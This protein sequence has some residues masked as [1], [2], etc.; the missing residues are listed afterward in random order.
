MKTAR[1]TNDPDLDKNFFIP[2]AHHQEDG[3]AIREYCAEC[4][5]QRECVD[6]ALPIANLRQRFWFAGMSPRELVELRKKRGVEKAATS[7][8]LWKSHNL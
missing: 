7:H 1:C 3:R 5:V 6:Y 4:P 8:M 2:R